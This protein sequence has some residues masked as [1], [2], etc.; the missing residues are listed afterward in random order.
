[1]KI[2]FCLLIKEGTLHLLGGIDGVEIF[3]PRQRK[4]INY[5]SLSIDGCLFQYSIVS[6]SDGLQAVFLLPECQDTTKHIKA[7]QKLHKA[8]RSDKAVVDEDTWL[9]KPETLQTLNK[10][11]TS[12]AADMK[13]E[14]LELKS[15]I[16][17]AG[18][19]APETMARVVYEP[20]D[21]EV[22]AKTVPTSIELAEAK[23][24]IDEAEIRR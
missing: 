9:Y 15:P 22:D 24:V 18:D 5:P 10:N 4:S 14:A 16:Q 1:M 8:A 6:A 3:G 12:M 11:H 20:S 21:E 7:F 17:F 23:E 13:N 19:P 2:P